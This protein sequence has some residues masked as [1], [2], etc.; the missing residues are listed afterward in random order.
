MT[1]ITENPAQLKEFRDDKKHLKTVAVRA[2][3]SNQQNSLQQQRITQFLPM[4]PKI[5]QKVVAYLRPPLSFED[6]VSAGTV[7]LVKAARDYEPNHQAEFKTYAYIR[8]KGAVLDELRNWSFVP[9]TPNRQIKNAMEMCQKITE[10]TGKTPADNEL[11][12]KLGIPL[13]KLYKIFEKARIRRFISIDGVDQDKPSLVSIL[14]NQDNGTPDKNIEKKELL[15]NLTKAI[16]ALTEK[17]RHTI[18]LYYQQHLNMKQIA[19]V[20]N[21]TESRV[22]QLHADALFNLFVKLRRF[23]DAR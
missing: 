7:G 2:Y 11:A 12:Q 13:D 16:T 21:I 1:I 19:E 6:L 15:E 5:V 10:K 17:Q 18:I 8:V 9:A 14:Q 22:S 23:E 3:S 20:F 4:V